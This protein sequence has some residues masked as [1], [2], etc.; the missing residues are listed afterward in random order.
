MNTT[1]EAVTRCQDLSWPEALVFIAVIALI[2]FGLYLM[3][4]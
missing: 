3:A 2:G 1:V 4:K